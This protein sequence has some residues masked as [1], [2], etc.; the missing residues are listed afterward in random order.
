MATQPVLNAFAALPWSTRKAVRSRLQEDLKASRV[1]AEC[2]VSLSDVTSHL[3]MKIPGY[4][5]FYTS[6]EH[7]QDVRST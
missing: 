3:P 2:L 1:P 7:C 6:L 4:S 5:D